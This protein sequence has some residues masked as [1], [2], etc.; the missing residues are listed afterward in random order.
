VGP[1]QILKDLINSEL[2]RVV[3]LQ[4]VFRQAA[5]SQIIQAA[6]CINQGQLPSLTK[7]ITSDF[8]FIEKQND[9]D[10]LNT[11]IPLCKWAMENF[12]FKPL[13]DI[14]FLT[15]MTKGL[16][17]THSL[18]LKLQEFFNPSK[19]QEIERF[20]II[21]KEGDK[22]IQIVNNYDKE[23]F[24]GDTG[25]IQIIDSEKSEVTV[26]FDSLVIYTFQELDQLKLAYA[27][28]I[29]KSQGSEYSC[30]IIPLTK[31]HT[32]MLRRNL[33]YTGITRGKKQVILIGQKQ[34]LQRAVLNNKDEKR[35]SL[36]PPY[37]KRIKD[38]E[39]STGDFSQYEITKMY[40][41]K[42]L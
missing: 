22:V 42:P 9:E 18:N 23:V 26:L 19:G 37:L 27:L 28:T 31:S 8:I 41:P 30:V 32:I 17:G 21:F 15:P 3:Y 33:I 1:G 6:H 39:C 7:S 11:L 5:E 4:E 12:K 13:S 14:Q 35:I 29:H 24:N 40:D 34:A 16:L 10:C 36:I 25:I 20:G 38:I 2:F